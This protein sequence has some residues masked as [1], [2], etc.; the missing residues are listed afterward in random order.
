MDRT[1]LSDLTGDPHELTN[2]AER[3]AHQAKGAELTSRLA[4]KMAS[5]ADTVPLTVA[6]PKPAAWTPPAPGAE[7]AKKAK[8]KAGK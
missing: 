1:Q 3:P 8:S 5:H 2:L 4:K 6:N 7:T